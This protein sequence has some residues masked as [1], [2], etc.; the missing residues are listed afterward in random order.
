[1]YLLLNFFSSGRKISA[2]QRARDALY[3]SAGDTG[4]QKYQERSPQE[5]LD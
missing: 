4:P 1:M 2:G 3:T 5:L